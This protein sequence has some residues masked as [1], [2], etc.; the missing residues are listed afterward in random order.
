MSF[1][2]PF[3]LKKA[4]QTPV[5]FTEWV[6]SY[7]SKA[8]LRSLSAQTV[9]PST[10]LDTVFAIIHLPL[11]YS[12]VFVF[13]S[14]S[15]WITL[16]KKSRVL[17]KFLSCT[18]QKGQAI[19]GAILRAIHF[20]VWSCC[21]GFVVLQANRCHCQYVHCYSIFT[22]GIIRCSDNHFLHKHHL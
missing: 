15:P 16:A 17:V 14:E 7:L 13:C 8:I 10:C 2:C 3:S 21:C 6:F 5:L 1:I 4:F 20:L 9:V 18:K 11:Q 12:P 19:E 22:E